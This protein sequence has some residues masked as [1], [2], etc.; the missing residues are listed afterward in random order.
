[1][2]HKWKTSKTLA[3]DGGQKLASQLMKNFQIFKGTVEE[4]PKK[5]SCW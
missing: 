3:K 5:L 1:M 2:P 4:K